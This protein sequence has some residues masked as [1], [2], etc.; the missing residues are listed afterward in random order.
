MLR[1]AYGV[2]VAY[3][4]YCGWALAQQPVEPP[5]ILQ[6]APAHQSTGV[7]ADSP[8][9]AAGWFAAIRPRCNA[10][11]VELTLRS[12]PP[13]LASREEGRSYV[14]GCFALAGKMDRARQTIEALPSGWRPRA[15]GIVFE[16]VHP[17]ADAGDDSS[18][19]PMMR[20]V[21][22]YW[23]EN[24]QALYHAG[25]SEYAL[26]DHARARQH[27]E[28]FLVLYTADDG[29]TRNAREVLARPG[30]R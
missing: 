11:E 2:G 23:P 29:W 19:G 16:I 30:M 28:K 21:L 24:F 26:D 18:A 3:L 8:G 7:S 15:A 27:L 13:P 17:V 4:A 9:T 6:T 5:L 1:V 20:L 12:T 22:E 25:M 14:A 10:V